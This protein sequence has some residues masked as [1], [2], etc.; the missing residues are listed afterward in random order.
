MDK[1]ANLKLS[2]Q[3]QFGELQGIYRAPGRVNLIGEHTDYNGGF[4]LPVALDFFCWVAAGRRS[5]QFVAVFS[6]NMDETAEADLEN[7][8]LHRSSRWDDYPIGVAWALREAGYSILG[9]NLYIRGEVPL[10]AG[11]SS[12]AAIEVATGYA[13]LELAGQQIKLLKLAQLCQRAENE[14]V[15]ARCGIMDQF[16]ACRGRAG[17]ALLLDCRSLEHQFVRLPDGLGLVICNTMV[18]HELSAGEYNSRRA[19]CE[20]GVRLLAARLPGISS[21]RDV[22]LPELEAHKSLLPDGVYRRC[23]HVITENERTL[24]AADA[25]RNGDLAQVGELMFASHRSLREDY[26][27]SCAELDLLVDLARKEPGLVGSRMTG[28]GFGGCT[29]NLVK[30]EF[31]EQFRDSVAAG[32][33]AET[34]RSP[35]IYLSNTAS[36]VERVV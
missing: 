19:Q 33:E 6:E 24:R 20:E 14:F 26:D 31:V 12:S 27:V 3:S 17:N 10:G 18:K 34:G 29:V 2:F 25:L 1:L 36:G 7:H 35:E 13:L 23:R 32:Y 8:G 15:G 30:K 21:L 11:L 5:D 16:I 4:V 22:S 28:G 9:A